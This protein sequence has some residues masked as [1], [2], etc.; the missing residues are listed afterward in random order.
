MKR[1]ACLFTAAKN[2]C[3]TSL[4]SSRSD[5]ILFL[6]L[7]ISGSLLRLR[8]SGAQ[9]I[10]RSGLRNNFVLTH[11]DSR[12]EFVRSFELTRRHLQK[13]PTRR[14]LVTGIND[15]AVLGALRAFEEAERSNRCLAASHGGSPKARRELRLPIRA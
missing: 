1:F 12:G 2:C 10:L 8:L 4:V 7:E 14:T 11:L 9:N 13:I 6:D 5:E 15:Y 3:A